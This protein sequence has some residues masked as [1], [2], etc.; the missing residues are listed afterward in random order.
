ML[1]VA[2]CSAI[3]QQVVRISSSRCGAEA[4][5][6][7]R[8]ELGALRAADLPPLRKPP[9]SAAKSPGGARKKKAAE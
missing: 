9:K 4:A 8:D 2:Q 3:P 1:I 7:L 5:V 6:F